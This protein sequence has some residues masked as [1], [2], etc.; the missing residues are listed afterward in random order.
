LD[1]IGGELDRLSAEV[2]VDGPAPGNLAYMIYTSGSTG[3]PKGVQITHRSLVNFLSSVRR[4]P[5]LDEHDKLLAVTTISFDIAA[6]ELFLPLIVGGTVIVADRATA[7]D[8]QKMGQAI[9]THGATFV[10]ATPASWRML[11]DAGWQPRVNL[12]IISGGEALPAE[13]AWRLV[14]RGLEVWNLYGPTETTVWSA[15]RRVPSPHEIPRNGFDP[16]GRPIDNTQLYVLDSHLWPQPI[17]VPGEL[18]IGGEGLARGYL[19]RPALTAERYCP[20]PFSGTPGARLYRTG[21]LVR[22]LAGG[23]I[24][25][26]GRLDNQVKIRGFRI[27][28]GEIESTLVQHQA[29]GQAVVVARDDG[30]GEKQLVGYVVSTTSTPPA[31]EELRAFLKLRLPEFMIPTA[32]VFLDSLPQTPNGKVDRKAL[33][34]PDRSRPEL[35]AVYQAPRTG[36]EKEIAA[37]WRA[38]LDVDRVGIDDNFFDLGGHSLLMTRVHA[39]LRSALAPN[40]SLVE[41]FQYPTVRAL[42]ARISP[43][44]MAATTRRRHR[45]ASDKRRDIAVIGLVGRFPEADD[46]GEFWR[47][48]REGRDSIRFFSDEELIAAGFMPT[49]FSLTSPASTRVSSASVP[50]KRKLWTHSTA[51]FW[52]VPGMF[53]NTRATAPASERKRW[54]SLRPAVTTAI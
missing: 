13:L 3:R 49:E 45:P 41:L 50:L 25:F 35:R 31:T 40:L 46:L 11:L 33:P 7:L 9:E 1:S 36:A 42:A 19:N 22:R 32:L 54:A 34:A 29:I 2:P 23:E 4:E 17:G 18:Y 52:R 12:R 15:V 21:D 30:L 14:N 24:E 20:D 28:L 37:I 47:N 5:G 39:R 43:G 53:W 6:L 51:F 48:L 10:Q 16:I 38:A 8:P 44:E 26:M 27:E